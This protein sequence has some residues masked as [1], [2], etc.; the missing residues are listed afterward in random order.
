MMTTISTTAQDQAL[1]DDVLCRIDSDPRVDAS[2]LDVEC[3]SGR[4]TLTGSVAWMYQKLAAEFDVKELPGVRALENRIVVESRVMPR[5][6]MDRVV[7]ALYADRS[8]DASHIDVSVSGRV[9]TLT[10]T[11]KAWVDK[12]TAERAAWRTPGVAEVRNHIEIEP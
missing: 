1:V 2:R 4:V 12:H 6:V 5:D 9:V 3:Q 8:I 10:G 7:G 11:V